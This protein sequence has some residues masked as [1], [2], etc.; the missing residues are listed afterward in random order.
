[1]GEGVGP[2]MVRSAAQPAAEHT[3]STTAST[4]AARRT[5][6]GRG[7]EVRVPGRRVAG[8][9]AAPGGPPGGEESGAGAFGEGVR[10]ARSMLNHRHWGTRSDNGTPA[11]PGTGIRRHTDHNRTPGPTASTTAK[12]VENPSESWSV[13]GGWALGPVGPGA[14]LSDQGLGRRLHGLGRPCSSGR[15][16][17]C[18][19]PVRCQSDPT[20]PVRPTCLSGVRFIPCGTRPGAGNGALGGAKVIPGAP[21]CAESFSSRLIG[22]SSGRGQRGAFCGRFAGPGPSSSASRSSAKVIQW[23][24]VRGARGSA[25]WSARSPGNPRERHLT[26]E[27]VC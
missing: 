16:G 23:A 20:R 12:P 18:L 27:N 19:I 7:G 3:P 26:R 11:V 6:R 22:E 5:T 8:R 21:G 10:G 17:R 4:T 9:R 2:V 25:W 15:V 1:M 24:V 13:R 14:G